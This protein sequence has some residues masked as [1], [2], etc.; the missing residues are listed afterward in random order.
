[1]AENP[2]VV[3]CHNIYHQLTPS[4]IRAAKRL[5]VPVVLTLHDF[6]PVC[7]TY[8]RL[9][10]GQPCSACLTGD[11]FSVVRHRCATGLLGRSVLLYGEA[12]FQRWLGSYE[13]L[14]HIIAPSQ[15]MVDAVTQW[16]FPKEK[17]S[18]VPN[19]IARFTSKL[20]GRDEGYLLYLG[21]LSAEKGLMT[22][23]EAHAGSGLR[24]VVA[25]AGPLE[26]ELRKRFLQVEFVGHQTGY[27]L[28]ALMDGAS[29]IVVPSEW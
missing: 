6:K 24:L 17:V 10:H 18:L 1:M 22:L 9:R 26:A 19:G 13:A 12:V 7:P 25:G 3:H 2:D 8:L 20:P 16:R 29:A 27:A 15:F 28:Q 14:D 23:G 11:F 5:G 21:R 4:I